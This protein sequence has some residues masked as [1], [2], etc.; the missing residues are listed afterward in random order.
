MFYSRKAAMCWIVREKSVVGQVG[1]CAWGRCVFCG[2]GKREGKETPDQ[3]KEKVEKAFKSLP[4]RLKIYTSGSFFDD[5]QYPPWLRL[6]LAE[7]L[8]KSCVEELQVETLPDFITYER[9]QPFLRRSYELI[10]ALGLEIADDEAL[11]LVGK[12]PAMTVEKFVSTSITLRNLGVKVKAYVLV[13]PPV[14]NWRDL[15]SKTVELALRYADEVVLINTYPHSDSP[16]FKM[17]V[18]RKWVPLAP[19]E[20]Y[21]VVR[22]WLGDPRV[23]I[24][25]SNFAFKPKFPKHMRVKIVGAD[26]R[27]LLHPYYEVW[28]DFLTKFYEPPKKKRIL[29]FVPCSYRKPYYKS[30]TWRAIRR[31]LREIGALRKVHMV[32][33]SSPGVIPEEFA[34]EYPFNAYDWPE[35]EETEEIK[36]KYI[37]VTKERVK[38]FLERHAKKYDAILIYLKPD[39]ESFRAVVEACEELGLECKPCIKEEHYTEEVKEFKPPV[40]HPR[41]LED[42]KE[43]VR[44]ALGA[45]G[46]I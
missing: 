18:E 27:A 4:K 30:K 42:L 38:R 36:R 6:W 15:L 2:W 28:L 41:L 39:S 23:Q 5:E 40:A 21:D 26:E 13:N 46:G 45:G 7:R 1:R 44:E 14:P 17:W 16:L 32:A 19:E 25:L 10:V 35:W 20:F 29:L 22:P 12:Y 11:K 31:A 43:C 8:D 33:V 9:L 24:D 34:D 37:E 3:F